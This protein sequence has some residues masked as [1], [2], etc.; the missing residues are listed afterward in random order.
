M[1]NA[2]ARVPT[3][4]FSRGLQG[5]N[6]HADRSYVTKGPDEDPFSAR[7][8]FVEINESRCPLHVKNLKAKR[9]IVFHFN[10]EYE[11]RG[12]RRGRSLN[13]CL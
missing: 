2:G 9:A 4:V 6:R 7:V 5:C 1:Q 3:P 10:V 12:E 11:C 8:S 13:P